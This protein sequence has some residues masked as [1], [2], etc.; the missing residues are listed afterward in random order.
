ML[1]LVPFTFVCIIFV[2]KCSFGTFIIFL[3]SCKNIYIILLL[4]FFLLIYSYSYHE[5]LLAYCGIFRILYQIFIIFFVAFLLF[6]C[7]A[8]NY[9]HC[10]GGQGH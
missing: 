10:S 8:R 2:K 9:F 3:L 1:A 5:F 6:F 4:V 7:L